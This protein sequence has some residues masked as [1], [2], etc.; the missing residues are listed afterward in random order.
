MA[1]E[2]LK[3]FSLHFL[4]PFHAC[5]YEKAIECP[6]FFSSVSPPLTSSLTSLPHCLPE[7]C[8]GSSNS[9][10]SSEFTVVYVYSKPRVM[11]VFYPLF[12]LGEMNFV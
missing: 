2:A 7:V 9:S 3:L 10:T 1:V 4:Y 6:Q 11:S 5:A 8:S 12:K